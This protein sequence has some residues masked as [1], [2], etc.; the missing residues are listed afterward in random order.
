MRVVGVCDHLGARTSGGA[1]KV[2]SEVYR[3]LPDHGLSV[4]AI[5]PTPRPMDSTEPH[6]G[7]PL[8][9]FPSVDL[10]PYLRV[11]WAVGRG[12]GGLVRRVIQQ[13]DAEVVHTNSLHF[14]G[15]VVAAR[16]ARDLRIPLVVTVHVG[17]IRYLSPTTRVA[18]EL[19]ER[20]VGRMILR[21]CDAVIAVSDDVAEHVERRGVPSPKITVVPNGV[22]HA[23]FF[24]R[25]RDAGSSRPTVTFVG[26]LIENKGPAVHVDAL[27]ELSRSGGEFTAVVAGDGPLR[28]SLERRVADAGL[29]DRVTFL[30]FVEDVAGVLAGSD[31]V[32]RP[33]Q[34]E[35]LSLALLEAMASGCAVIASRIPAN[36]AVIS[37]HETGLLVAP[38]D[39]GELAQALRSLLASTTLRARLADAAHQRSLEFSWDR[40]AGATAEVLRA[41]ARP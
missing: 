30:G 9:R 2:A 1:E 18:A 13:A 31:I 37:D 39:V 38:G 7:F 12:L 23:L 16:V 40:A 10:T 28:R 24:P 17:D 29:A 32:V 34:T 41:A 3:R 36:A 15:S 33:S 6:L 20:T 14:Y 35:G 11:Q 25:Q 21:S 27:I 8:H 5:S 4:T 26:R 19:Y 22:D